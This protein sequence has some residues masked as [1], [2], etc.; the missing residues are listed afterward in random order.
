VRGASPGA[1]GRAA[2]AIVLGSLMF[3]WC[4]PATQAKP[5]ASRET[6]AKLLAH[7]QEIVRKTL[8]LDPQQ[9]AAFD[10]VYAR[11]EQE[12]K[13]LAEQRNGFVDHFSDA[14]LSMSN[15]QASA[16]TDRF[17]QLRTQRIALDEKF[18]PEFDA[19]LPPQKTLLLFQLNF[20]LDAVVNYDLAGMIPLVQ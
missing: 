3:A 2:V 7:R 14:A 1:G 4:T 9:Q 13:A 5:L 18:R 8:Q 17:M 15:E 12:R 10:P 6:L 16:L 11:Y 20:I 19:V